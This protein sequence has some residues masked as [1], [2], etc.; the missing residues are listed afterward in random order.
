MN[1]SNATY[2]VTEIG[3]AYVLSRNNQF[4]R[5]FQNSL[6]AYAGLWN[7]EALDKEHAEYMKAEAA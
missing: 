4:I 2:K 5:S 6:D 7:L 1:Y 3:G